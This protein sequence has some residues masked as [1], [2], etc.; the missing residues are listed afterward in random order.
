MQ[1]RFS[2]QTLTNSR[3]V[4]R[5]EVKG[6]P[7]C[8]AGNRHPVWYTPNVSDLVGHQSHCEGDLKGFEDVLLNFMHWLLSK[9][10]AWCVTSSAL[11]F[12]SCCLCYTALC[13][14]VLCLMSA[15]IADDTAGKVDLCPNLHIWPR[16]LGC[17]GVSHPTSV[18]KNKTVYRKALHIREQR[19][20]FNEYAKLYPQSIKFNTYL[21]PSISHRHLISVRCNEH[22][23]RLF[24][25]RQSQTI[26]TVW[27]PL[28][29]VS[30]QALGWNK[31]TLL[32]L[33]RNY[34]RNTHW[35]SKSR[36]RIISCAR[37]P[38]NQFES[39]RLFQLEAV[40]WWENN[41]FENRNTQINMQRRWP[42]SVKV[43]GNVD[44]C[45]DW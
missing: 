33:D 40:K 34:C 8:P 17:L 44:L 23:C 30:S 18:P 41:L 16:T 19:K 35:V 5:L 1:P 22:N 21:L 3:A 32:G 25:V 39:A 2:L 11:R 20:S 15:F 27:W 31:R 42:W 24:L 7:V 10:F 37:V 14:D 45:Y 26:V 28:W 36:C 12:T 13:F 43:T 6:S 4:A 29:S 9:S 38:D